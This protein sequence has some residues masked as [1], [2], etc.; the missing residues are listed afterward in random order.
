MGAREDWE[1]VQSNYVTIDWR[2]AR[3]ILSA[4][5]HREWVD[6]LAVLA[7]FRL[8]RSEV[9]TPGGRK[10]K[11][12]DRLDHPL[13]NKGWITKRFDSKVQVDGEVRDNPTHEIDCFKNRIALE[14]EWNNKDPFFDRDL[15]NFRVLFDLNAISVG[16]I[17][18]RGDEL[19]AIFDSLGRGSSYGS[20]T[21]HW[22]KL[23][24]RV[25]GGGSGG[26]PVLCFGITDRLYVEDEVD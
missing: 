14:V 15:N 20:S 19:Q 2:H 13:I 8:L 17:I 21:T 7:A 12:A 23:R 4:D 3:S 25:A 5:F 18:T 16:V 11:V 1:F 22:S 24:P 9:A 26:C 10:S 6:I